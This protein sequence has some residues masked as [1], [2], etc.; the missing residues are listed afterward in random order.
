MVKAS[1]TP[2]PSGRLRGY[3]G[4]YRNTPR[5]HLVAS[6]V[7]VVT[8]ESPWLP[9]D[10]RLLHFHA[11][12]GP[13]KAR[14]TAGPDSTQGHGV[15]AAPCDDVRPRTSLSN[16]GPL[17]NGGRR[18]QSAAPITTARPVIFQKRRTAQ[19][20]RRL[21]LLTGQGMVSGSLLPVRLSW[22]E[23]SGSGRA[24]RHGSPTVR[25]ASRTR[26][27]PG[28]QHSI[29]TSTILLIVADPPSSSAAETG[30]I[31]EKIRETLGNSLDSVPASQLN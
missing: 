31:G 30:E 6:I 14:W 25:E 24:P 15:G 3:G 8:H 29:S 18:Q 4:N 17:S 13:M 22:G 28:R 11:A 10:A 19:G 5:P 16:G 21:R 9:E 2:E 23:E 1:Y 27:R 12:P 7:G 20:E 26:G